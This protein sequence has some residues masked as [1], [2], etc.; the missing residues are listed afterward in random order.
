MFYNALVQR[1]AGK[2]LR[3]T[4][5]MLVL[6]ANLTKESNKNLAN[7]N[8][9]SKETMS[10]INGNELKT[11][12]NGHFLTLENL[13]PAVKN[14]Q[15]AVRGKI[16]IR[17]GEIEKE[18]KQGEKKP[19]ERVIRANIGDC[20]ATG[21][22]PMTFLRQVMAL[23]SYPE[24][25]S[26]SSFPADA[27]ERA[28]RILDSCGGQSV[29]AYT[30]S[31]GLE[32]IRKDVADFITR[33]DGGI[34]ANPDDIFLTTGASS[35]IKIVMELLLNGGKGKP[36]GFMI[37]IPQYPLYTATISEYGAEKVGYYLDEDNGWS[38]SIQELERSYEQSLSYCEPRAICIINPGNPTGQVLSLQNMQEIVK[39]AYEKKLFILADEVYQDNIYIDGMRFHSFKKVAAELGSPYS[40]MEIASFYST[41]KGFMGECGARGGFFEIAN[42]DPAVKVELKKLSSAQLCSGVLGQV[43][44]DAVVNPPKPG[45]PS[46]ELFMKEKTAVLDGLKEKAK[47]VT[48]LFNKIKGIKCN[49]VQGAMYAFPQIT[50]P[51]KAIEHAKSKQMEPDMFYCLELLE[52]T[53]ICVVP[54]SGF[55]QKPNTYHFRTT[56]LP[57]T[58]QIKTLLA[59]FE[60]FHLNFMQKWQ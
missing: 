51:A 24:L 30:D 47:L 3:T 29:G 59:K 46:Y 41:S 16:V 50:I 44:M 35:G 18:L 53:G 52:S 19:F 5:S 57:P 21:Q 37:P 56:I 12:H 9:K 36:T 1:G 49:P 10:D 11:A 15:Y 38:L 34:P 4:S 54:G 26:N 14:V 40:K 42:L 23:C 43:C 48:E 32:V 20:H 27:K 7:L 2:A 55:H 31:T 22:K 28:Q 25:M 6:N 58:D 13:S 39:W 60:E 45:E 33:R 17:A 8:P